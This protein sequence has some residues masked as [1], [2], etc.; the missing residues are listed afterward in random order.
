MFEEYTYE[1]ILER[2]LSR[3][4]NSLDKR[5]GSIIYD[6]IAPA[7]LEIAGVYVEL[8]NAIDFTFAD[9]APRDFLKK[10]ALE[11]GLIPKS[12]TKSLVKAEFN[13][14]VP[15]GSRFSSA[16]YDWVAIERI[17]E[18]QFKLECESTG[19]NANTERGL[20]IP[21]EYIEGLERANIVEILID[22]T[23]EED[24]EVFRKRYF[25]SF[26]SSAFSGNRKDYYDKITGLNGVGGC[27][28]LR[29]TNAGGESEAGQVLALICSAEFG[30]PSSEVVERVQNSM[31]PKKDGN[32]DG[33]VPIGHICT[34]K[35]VEGLKID[36]TTT[37]TFDIGFNYGSVESKVLKAIDGYFYELNKTWDKVNNIVVRISAL[38]SEL[39]KVDGIVDVNNTSL[40]KR[41]E[42]I[43]LESNQIA[44]RGLVNG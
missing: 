24:T 18:G 19:K 32:G 7:C 14:D 43:I 26:K 29:T 2:V 41:N 27:K 10:R 37:F 35:A 31:D 36:I 20:L 9:T 11:R 21:T 22:G 33:L 30:I 38:E 17:S 13:V 3:I 28:V 1:K 8:S 44:I 16:R 23:D 4:D 25:D 34:I 6:A 15:I 12:A 40:N 5:E 39:L 42:N